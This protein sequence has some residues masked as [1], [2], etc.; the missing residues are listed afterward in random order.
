[1]CNNHHCKTDGDKATLGFVVANAAQ[2][3][4]KETWSSSAPTASGVPTGKN[5][6][7]NEGAPFASLKNSL[8]IRQGRG[9]NLCLHP[10]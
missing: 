2:G 7:V 9:Q 5:A 4:E 6:K 3:S 1:L 8:K 10:S